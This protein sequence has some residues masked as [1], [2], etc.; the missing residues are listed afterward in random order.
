MRAI[1]ATVL[2]MLL[3]LALVS[4]PRAESGS[5]RAG[6][7]ILCSQP[8]TGSWSASV[9]DENNQPPD[10]CMGQGGSKCVTALGAAS[11]QDCAQFSPSLPSVPGFS[12]VGAPQDGGAGAPQ[13]SYVQVTCVV[14]TKAVVDGREVVSEQRS[15][16]GMQAHWN[17]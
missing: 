5:C 6:V 12:T 2:I 7:Q 15:C 17:N 10:A 16:A 4:G 8:G 1:L 9:V 14:I 3:S 11:V 13:C